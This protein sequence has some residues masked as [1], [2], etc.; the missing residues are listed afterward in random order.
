MCSPNL[1]KP[2]PAPPPPPAPVD[3]ADSFMASKDMKTKRKPGGF[4]LDLL[5]IPMS[6]SNAG[7]G[8]NI[9]GT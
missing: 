8:A 4:G 9:P 1:P 7:S 6:L 3:M 5:T 2:Q